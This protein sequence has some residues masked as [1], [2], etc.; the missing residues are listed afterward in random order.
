MLLILAISHD[1]PTLVLLYFL[2]DINFY[3][4]TS[5]MNCDFPPS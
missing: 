3:V 1:Q 5:D 4:L 2:H